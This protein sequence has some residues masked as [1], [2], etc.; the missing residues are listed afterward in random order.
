VDA[1]RLFQV[2]EK[3]MASLFA[4]MKTGETEKYL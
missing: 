4:S 3:R 2:T 1:F